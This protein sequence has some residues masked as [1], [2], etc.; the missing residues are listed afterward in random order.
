MW[1]ASTFEFQN[2]LVMLSE[3]LADRIF[4]QK[5]VQARGLPA[6]DFPWPV[7]PEHEEASED[8]KKLYS[9][10]KLGTM[11]K[12]LD[13]M[14][15]F[16]PDLQQ[17]LKG[18]LI[19]ADAKD[20]PVNT[21]RE[22]GR[23]ITGNFGIPTQ[24]LTPFPSQNGRPNIGVMLIPRTGRGSL[25]TICVRAMYGKMP[26]VAWA[27]RR[28]LRTS[29]ISVYKW[30]RAEKRSKAKYACLV[31]ATNE[32]DPTRALRNAFSG[33]PGKPPLIDI[34]AL[35]FRSIANDIRTFCTTVGVP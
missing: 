21:L 31:A 3:G 17:N 35:C 11:L 5:L 27:M 4:L 1:K 9:F 20:D 23:Q 19:V 18:V 16:R 8:A 34:N 13:D 29:P 14:I 10:D 32:D 12:T 30:K 6:F 24:Q 15:Q 2:N 26:R 7:D 25:E 22:L 33:K 28:Y